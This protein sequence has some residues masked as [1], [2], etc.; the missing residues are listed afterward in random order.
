MPSARPTKSADTGPIVLSGD[1]YHYEAER[2]LDRMPPREV[3]PG[4][5][6]ASRAAL[7]AF[8]AETTADLWIQHEPMQWATRRKSPAY[9]E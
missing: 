7:E 2:T 3:G 6:A 9:Y 5:T 1:L 4:L 8:I